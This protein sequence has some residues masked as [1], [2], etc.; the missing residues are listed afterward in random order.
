LRVILE[1]QIA[2]PA[3]PTD[4]QIVDTLARHGIGWGDEQG[5]TAYPLD[6]E[7]APTYIGAVRELLAAPS[8]PLQVLRRQ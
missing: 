3:T 1:G 8:L 5:V 7:D 6:G 2:A 4:Q